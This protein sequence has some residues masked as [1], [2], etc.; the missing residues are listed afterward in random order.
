MGFEAPRPFAPRYAPSPYDDLLAKLPDR[1][2]AGRLGAAFLAEN[3]IFN[4]DKSARALRQR[5]SARTLDSAMD[6][7]LAQMRMTEVHGWV[8]PETLV[9]LCALAAKTLA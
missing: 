4:A 8:L 5:L 2:S 6:S 1:D 3:K 7:D 9:I